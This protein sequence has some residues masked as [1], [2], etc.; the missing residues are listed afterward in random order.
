MFDFFYLLPRWVD[1]CFDIIRWHPIKLFSKKQG[2]CRCGSMKIYQA[3]TSHQGN[4]HMCYECWTY[5]I[6]KVVIKFSPGR[7]PKKTKQL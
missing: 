1:A 5:L 2:C 3:P 7:M 4:R 6:D